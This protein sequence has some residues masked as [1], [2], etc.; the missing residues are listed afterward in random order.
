MLEYRIT[1]SADLKQ[2]LLTADKN[3]KKIYNFLLVTSLRKLFS[4]Y[5][6]SYNTKIYI[7]KNYPNELEII[8]KLGSYD[9]NDYQYN[10]DSNYVF[11]LN[12]LFLTKNWESILDFFINHH[13]PNK[14]CVAFVSYYNSLIK[15]SIKYGITGLLK[16]DAIVLLKNTHNSIFFDITMKE[17]LE[18]CYEFDAVY[19]NYL[20]S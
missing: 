10:F 20:Y 5:I 2:K 18:E 15:T 14:N 6:G 16:K 19:F 13:F 4:Y 9:D 12:F 1:S 11:V 7:S 17:A 3:S 8:N